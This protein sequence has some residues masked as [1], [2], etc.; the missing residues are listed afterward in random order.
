MYDKVG[1]KYKVK[2][3]EAAVAAECGSEVEDGG[4]LWWCVVVVQRAFG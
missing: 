4:G 2:T 3:Q 1:A